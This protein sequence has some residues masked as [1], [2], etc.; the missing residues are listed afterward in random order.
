MCVVCDVPVHLCVSVW[1]CVVPVCGCLSRAVRA[2]YG[3][4]CVPVLRV[5]CVWMECMVSVVFL[6]PMYAAS[7]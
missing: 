6:L 5:V 1:A 7:V 2:R 3:S 4:A